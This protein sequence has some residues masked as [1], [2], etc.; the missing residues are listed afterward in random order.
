[1]KKVTILSLIMVVAVLFALSL[2]NKADGAST[3]VQSIS[4]EFFSNEIDS[5]VWE[6]NGS[7]SIVNK[8]GAI[9]IKKGDFSTS[10]GWKGLRDVVD[11][12]GN[13]NGLTSDYSLE[14][15][16][17]CVDTSWFAVYLGSA[18]SAQRFSSINEGN[19]ASIL[20][21]SSTSITHYVGQ[22]TKATDAAAVVEAGSEEAQADAKAHKSVYGIN[23][24]SFDGSRYCLKL[25]AHFGTETG[26]DRSKNY[27][28]VYLVMEIKL[29]EFIMHM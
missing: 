19:P 15:T 20:V 10:V 14:L 27:I 26:E 28:D 23:K 24:L 21:F 29:L 3:K 22:G 13:G 17:S 1:M 16:I 12:T 25:D 9:Q 2:V 6:S 7:A 11:K 18:K 4:D 5:E 8:G